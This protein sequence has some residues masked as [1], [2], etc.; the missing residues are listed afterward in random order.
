[1]IHRIK[2]Q[3][4]IANNIANA[5]TPGYKKDSVFVNELSHAQQR[6]FP[7]KSDWQTPMIDQ[8]YTDFSQGSFDR[9]GAELDVAIDGDG[10]FVV[11]T[12]QGVEALIRG[13][14]L[15]RDQQGFL[16]TA[17]NDAVQSDGGPIQLPIGDVSIADDGAISVNGNVVGRLRV[18]TIENLNDLQR[19]GDG[20]FLVPENVELTSAVRFVVRQGYLESSNV[21]VVTQMVDMIASY[22]NYEADANSLKTQDQSLAKL[23]SEVGRAI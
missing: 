23:I 16:K 6:S 21:N 18:A 3:E 17:D 20:K 22:R 2:E 13:G 14:A 12:E 4:S 10:F 1:M 8:V 7:R 5:S 19:L 9:T 11:K 15:T